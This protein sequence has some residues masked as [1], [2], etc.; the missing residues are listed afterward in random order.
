MGVWTRVVV[1]EVIRLETIF[2]VEEVGVVHGYVNKDSSF[3]E[4]S[5]KETQRNWTV[6]EDGCGVMGMI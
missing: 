2:M 6:A 4:F 3:K 5:F 1:R